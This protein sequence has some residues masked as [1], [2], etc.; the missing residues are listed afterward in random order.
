[1]SLSSRVAQKA[2]SL[3]PPH[4]L[5]DELERVLQASGPS[6]RVEV[7]SG[8]VRSISASILCPPDTAGSLLRAYARLPLVEEQVRKRLPTYP[9]AHIPPQLTE[10]TR[11][12]IEGGMIR[13]TF[14]LLNPTTLKRLTLTVEEWERTAL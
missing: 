6:V 4:P 2:A 13:L 12:A 14:P 3:T 1:M 10:D 5:R 8:I 11:V 7:A 9:V